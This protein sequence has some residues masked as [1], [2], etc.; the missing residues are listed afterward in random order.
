MATMERNGGRLYYEVHDLT[1]PWRAKP[2]TIVFHHGVGTDAGIWSAWL[3]VLAPHY[4]LVRFDT[5][6]FGRSHIPGAGFDWSL[7]LLVDDVLAVAEAAGAGRFH[8]VG[9]SLG[10]T[11]AMALAAR[12]PGVLRS[13][14]ACSASHRGGSIQRVRHWREFIAQNGVEAWSRDMMTLRFAKGAVPPEVAAWFHRTQSA[15][16]ADSLL[17]LADLLIGTDLSP[18]LGAIPCP[19]LLLA[20]DS[21]PFVPL[22]LPVEVRELIPGAELMVFPGARHGLACSHGHACAE[23]LRDFLARRT[24]A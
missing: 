15:C 4:R 3:P 9:E 7:H 8:L 24:S 16:S 21:S 1:P 13:L 22:A 14:T 20:P 19:T 12:H 2:E 23:A 10:G 5:R 11:V 17:D 6:G 18:E